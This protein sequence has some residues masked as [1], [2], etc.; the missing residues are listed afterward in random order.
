[1]EVLILQI[2]V[3]LALVAG[4]LLLFTHSLRR[5]DHE[6]ADRLALLALEDDLDK[7]T[8]KE[9]DSER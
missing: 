8:K 7:K 9:N 5:R 4:S 1:V 2:F 6:H 3:S